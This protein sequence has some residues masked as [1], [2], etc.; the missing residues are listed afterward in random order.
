MGLMQNERKKLDI[1]RADIT[2]ICPH[3]EHKVNK[4]IEVSRGYFAVNRVFCCPR[5]H[6]ILGMS[7]GQ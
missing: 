2:P 5:C 4:L 1:E 3:C 6:K 7:A